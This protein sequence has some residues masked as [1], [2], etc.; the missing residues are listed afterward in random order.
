MD[1]NIHVRMLNVLIRVYTK[2]MYSYKLTRTINQLDN[3]P[4]R[5]EDVFGYVVASGCLIPPVPG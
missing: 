2:Q 3:E 5:V 4:M 1:I